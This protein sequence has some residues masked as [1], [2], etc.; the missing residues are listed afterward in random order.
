MTK[1]QRSSAKRTQSDDT[2]MA[3]WLIIRNIRIII[4]MI[5]PPFVREEILFQYKIDF[6][7]QKWFQK[8]ITKTVVNYDRQI[9]HQIITI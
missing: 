2:I 3:G 8:T 9:S 4:R 6:G 7:P 5:D 1:D